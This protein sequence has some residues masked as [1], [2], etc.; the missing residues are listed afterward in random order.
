MIIL[1][2]ADELDHAK[3]SEEE[4]SGFWEK[5]RRGTHLEKEIRGPNLEEEMRCREKK[6]RLRLAGK[7]KN[8]ASLSSKELFW[9]RDRP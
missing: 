9:A 2:C 8:S 7:V 5:G 3:T 4:I 1:G 6:N